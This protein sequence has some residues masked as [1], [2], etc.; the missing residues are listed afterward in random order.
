MASPAG[1]TYIDG[2]SRKLTTTPVT[3]PI[4]VSATRS[5]ATVP[6]WPATAST[7]MA[8]IGTSRVWSPRRSSRPMTSAARMVTPRLHQVRPTTL[9]IS[10]ATSTPATTLPTR[11]TL[12]L[13][14]SKMVSW[15][16]SRA[17][18]GASSGGGWSPSSHTASR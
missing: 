6:A 5:M 17:V 4:R 9:E 16:T 1:W 10:A 14:V 18:S 12:L 2:R 8:L 7:S 3:A 15:A 13:T 11:S